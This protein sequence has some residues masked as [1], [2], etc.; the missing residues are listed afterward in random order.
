MT[1][2]YKGDEKLQ[3]MLQQIQDSFEGRV[4]KKRLQEDVNVNN[5]LKDSQKA[6]DL[7]NQ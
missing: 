7:E 5:A 4:L 1:Q 3:L 6:I 2:Q